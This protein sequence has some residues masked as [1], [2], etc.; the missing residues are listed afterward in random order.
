MA[1]KAGFNV[2]ARLELFVSLWIHSG[3]YLLEVQIFSWCVDNQAVHV[4]PTSFVPLV[5][6]AVRHPSKTSC[7]NRI[8]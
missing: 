1:Y 2:D 8:V 3:R 7:Y 4:S 6:E 5:S